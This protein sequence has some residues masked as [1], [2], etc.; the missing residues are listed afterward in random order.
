MNKNGISDDPNRN[1]PVSPSPR[2][3]IAAG[4][5]LGVLAAALAALLLPTVAARLRASAT[6]TQCSDSLRG[7]G[8]AL[9]A[10]AA[11]NGGSHP[12]DL[13][14]LYPK[15]VGNATL[16]SCPAAPSKWKD[17]VEGR[18][19]DRATVS[20]IYVS[21]LREGDPPDCV[22]AFDRPGNHGGA[23]LNV[24]FSGAR[25]R[26]MPESELDKAIAATRELAAKQGREIRLV[27]E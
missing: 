5:V 16:Y 25:V 20:Y 17:L 12:P 13:S 3:R 23:G 24:M 11:D 9:A 7:I 27:G 15:H 4:I 18:R 10:Y 1:A 2:R 21:G 26:W 6:R 22:L 19:L 8:L 14:S